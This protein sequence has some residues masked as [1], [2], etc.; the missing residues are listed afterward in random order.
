MLLNVEL[1][2]AK[3]QFVAN[4]PVE[5]HAEMFRLIREQQQSGLGFGLQ[6]GQK[7][8]DFTLAN[9]AGESVNLY[10]E[11]F[12]GPVVLTFYRGGWCP[13]SVCSCAPI[14]TY[15]RKFGRLAAS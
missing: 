3:K 8:K 15:C 12:K 1:D 9:A 4:T 5:V 10:E 11:L 2:E 6:E 14:R 13:F 7:A